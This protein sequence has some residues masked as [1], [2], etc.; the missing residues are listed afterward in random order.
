MNKYLFTLI[1][2]LITSVCLAD[3]KDSKG[4]VHL[5]KK[6]EDP[7][8][9]FKRDPEKVRRDDERSKAYKEFEEKAKADG[10]ITFGALKSISSIN[11]GILACRVGK[12]G[13]AT[14]QVF[15]VKNYSSSTV[16]D[17]TIL[18]LCAGKENGTFQ[19]K[20]ALG[21]LMTVKVLECISV[22]KF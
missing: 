4:V 9:G 7:G 13:Q 18:T 12:D 19:Y 20:N 1:L 15:L 11:D 10:L 2:T 6:P 22:F 16:A 5:G 8:Q 17:G 21:S 14:D 3:Y